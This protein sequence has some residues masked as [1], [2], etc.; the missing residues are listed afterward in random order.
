MAGITLAELQEDLDAARSARLK[1]LK[2]QAYAQGGRSNT[3]A[4]LK[5]VN[6]LIN[7]LN[8]QI[9]GFSRNIRVTGGTPVG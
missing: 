2:S 1:I 9:Q 7:D 5:A 3:R 8:R 4:E 6:D